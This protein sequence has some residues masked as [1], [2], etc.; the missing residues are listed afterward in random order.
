MV[1]TYERNSLLFVRLPLHLGSE[2][3]SAVEEG[4]AEQ[5]RGIPP[6]KSQVM[7]ATPCDRRL[8][9]EPYSARHQPNRNRRH[10]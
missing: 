2:I 6:E 5:L 3:T 7:A 9:T 8:A 4:D 10:W 1:A